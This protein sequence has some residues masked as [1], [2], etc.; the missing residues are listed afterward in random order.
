VLSINSRLLQQSKSSKSKKAAEMTEDTS[1][2]HKKWQS[3][4][5]CCQ[6]STLQHH[7]NLFFMEGIVSTWPLDDF[8]AKKVPFLRWTEDI[9]TVTWIIQQQNQNSIYIFVYKC[10][11]V[12]QNNTEFQTNGENY[13]I[14]ICGITDYLEKKWNKVKYKREKSTVQNRF[15]AYKD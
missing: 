10:G 4:S 7:T 13:S 2:F 6:F 11:D 14:S 12:L 5:L 15:S 8:I 1:S 3:H 9:Q